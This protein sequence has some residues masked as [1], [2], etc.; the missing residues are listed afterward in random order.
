MQGCL[1]SVGGGSDTGQTFFFVFVRLDRLDFE[2]GTK[3]IS[4]CQI[5]TAA[6]FLLRLR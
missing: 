4:H 2:V 3:D 1:G 5:K 6:L